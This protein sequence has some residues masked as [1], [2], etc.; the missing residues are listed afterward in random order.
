MLLAGLVV[1]IIG[2]G[3]DDHRDEEIRAQKAADDEKAE[4]DRIGDDAK[5]LGDK[6]DK[7]TGEVSQ[8]EQKLANLN[9]QRQQQVAS[10]NASFDRGHSAFA[11][12][13]LMGGGHTA[14]DAA[15]LCRTIQENISDTDYHIGTC[16]DKIDSLRGDLGKTKQWQADLTAREA[17]KAAA[18]NS[19]QTSREMARPPIAMPHVPM[20]AGCGPRR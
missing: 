3:C 12:L 10:F 5:G 16:Q 4:K 8:W 13:D 1:G 15:N 19:A 7:L 14:Q 2:V 9:Q 11:H 6:A 18:K 17:A 20:P